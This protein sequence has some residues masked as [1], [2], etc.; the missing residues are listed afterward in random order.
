MRSKIY[1]SKLGHEATHRTSPVTPYY[2]ATVH[3]LAGLGLCTTSVSQKGS[4]HI[5][6]CYSSNIPV[7]GRQGRAFL[8]RLE[9]S[10][11]VWR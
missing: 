5:C 7:W 1:K 8:A 10:L 4:Q 2:S 3:L 9:R 11:D 6:P